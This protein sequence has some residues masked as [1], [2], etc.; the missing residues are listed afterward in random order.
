MFYFNSS[1]LLYAANILCYHQ[2]D[3]IVHVAAHSFNYFSIHMD[4]IADDYH[5]T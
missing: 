4:Q 1:C 3:Y 2:E 5:T